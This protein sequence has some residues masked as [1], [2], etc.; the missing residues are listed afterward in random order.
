MNRKFFKGYCVVI[1]LILFLPLLGTCVNFGA[2]LVDSDFQLKEPELSGVVNVPEKPEI[3]LTNL[4]SGTFQDELEDY[5]EYHLF[6]RRILTRTYNQLLYSVF[7]STDNREMLVGQDDYVFEKA[8]ATAY[9]TELTDEEIRALECS[10]GRVDKLHDLLKERGITLVVRMS[11]SKAELYPEYLPSAYDRFVEMKQG[12]A[13]A[14]NWYQAFIDIISKTDIPVYD[15][16]DMLVQ[17]KNAGEIVFAKG[18]THWTLA[19]M[20]EYI[21]GL[22]ALLEELLETKLGR[23]VVTQK[24]N[25][26]G[27]MGNVDDSDIWQI[28]WN[29][30]NAEPNYLSPHIQYTSTAGE[31]PLHVF[32]VGQSFST[33]LLSTIYS[34]EKPVWTETY[35]SWYNSQVLQYKAGYTGGGIQFSESTDDFERYLQADVIIVEFLENGSGWIQFE[36]VENMLHYLEENEETA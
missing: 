32:M 1:A 17:M 7:H 30:L 4:A 15:R 31:A 3:S 21:N 18:G 13:Y 28:C 35:F 8:Y 25:I 6:A 20:A 27:Q 9:L 11:P 29:A 36:F 5:L 26:L 16:H 12:G 19:P 34:V 22:N 23:M 14:A 2:R 10:I 24:E 33:L